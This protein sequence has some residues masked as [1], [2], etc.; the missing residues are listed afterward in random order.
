[1]SSES[2]VKS[3]KKESKSKKNE[4]EDEE[5]M[6]SQKVN[7]NVDNLDYLLFSGEFERI[8]RS[9]AKELHI[10]HRL[11]VPIQL[12][13]RG[14]IKKSTEKIRDKFMKKTNYKIKPILIENI[15]W[16]EE[17]D[18]ILHFLI[19][20][21]TKQEEH[22]KSE[23]EIKKKISFLETICEKC[24]AEI[25]TQAESNLDNLAKKGKSFKAVSF[26]LKCLESS[27]ILTDMVIVITFFRNSTSF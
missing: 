5:E 22:G 10:E 19:D 13:N 1:M 20:I 15:N 3:F 7:G 23:N 4:K 25:Q 24:Q 26:L 6:S 27:K 9:K 14:I 12:E 21:Y 17:L 2:D 8:S 18:K 16:E 11:N